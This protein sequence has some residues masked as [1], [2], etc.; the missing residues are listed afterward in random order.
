MLLVQLLKMFFGEG[1]GAPDAAQHHLDQLIAAP[2]AGL[3]QKREQEGVALARL[4]YVQQVAYLRRGGLGR[5]LAQLGVGDAVQQRTGIDKAVQPFEALG[6]ELD[7]LGGRKPWRLLQLVEIRRG[8]AERL[9][10]QGIQRS[11]VLGRDASGNA[12]VHAPMDFGAQPAHQ[13]V[14]GAE[15]RQVGCCGAQRFNGSVDEV[16]RV[17]HGFGGFEDSA[18][19]KAL[20]LIAIRL[21]AQVGPHGG[22][23][24]VERLGPPHLVRRGIGHGNPKLR[25]QMPRDVRMDRVRRWKVPKL[26]AGLEQHSQQQPAGVA[27]GACV[28]EGEFGVAQVVSLT[29]FLPGQPHLRVWIGC[30]VDG[31]HKVSGKGCARAARQAM[32]FE[33]LSRGPS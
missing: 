5:E 21:D 26:A 3:A 9:D 8:A 2:H 32:L 17:A 20:G 4:G 29:L 13:P 24:A 31:G 23:V 28:D 14:K 30:A 27:A 7:R 15:R 11:R 12:A 6:P 10:Q 18:G 16:G 1:L 19:N 22:L 25:G 33:G